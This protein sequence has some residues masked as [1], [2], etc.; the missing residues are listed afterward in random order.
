[1]PRLAREA[2]D[3]DGLNRR[4]SGA[5]ES[6]VMD[7]L[8]DW[9]HAPNDRREAQDL[10]LRLAR[11][12]EVDI[13]PRLV[14]VHRAAP[15]APSAD[16]GGVSR[17]SSQDVEDFVQMVLAREQIPAQAF[18]DVLRQRG[19]S[20]ETV[21]LDL[22][23]PAAQ[24]L[25]YLWTQDLCEFTQVT[26]GL[27]R[28]QQLLHALSP[29]LDGQPDSRTNARRVLLMP[30]RGEH[31]T[32]GLAMVAEFFHRAGWEV[33]CGGGDT[34]ADAVHCVDAQW[35]DV[36][37]LSAG[38]DTSLDVLKACVIDLRRNSRNREIVVLVGGPIFAGHPERV[39]FVGAD[40]SGLDGKQAP[41]QAERLIV[42]HT[43][44][45]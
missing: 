19:M 15:A 9:N 13:I 34:H 37:G 38:S 23:A 36:V 20:V 22:L 45:R 44:G 7:S 4:S 21:Y 26:L 30:A 43:R 11:T 33:D 41:G 14:N 17:P 40:A 12:L 18:I 5:R 25:S 16:A 31:Q 29:E 10:H 24:H 35:F 2:L 6:S 8:F 3:P 28:M 27:A 1:M 39:K 32:F 42:R